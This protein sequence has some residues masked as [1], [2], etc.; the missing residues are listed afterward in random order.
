MFV[1]SCQ[2]LGTAHNHLQVSLGNEIRV[3]NLTLQLCLPNKDFSTIGIT[4]T[5]ALHVERVTV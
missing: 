2:K 1:Y 3:R 4:K 5:N